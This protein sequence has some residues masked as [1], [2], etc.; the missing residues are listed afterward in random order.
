LIGTTNSSTLLAN[1]T[2]KLVE[3]VKPDTLYIQAT[4]NWWKIAKDLDVN[5]FIC[6]LIPNLNFLRLLTIY[7]RQLNIFQT[8]QEDSYQK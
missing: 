1:R 5:I 6:R 4:S 8:T 7:Q 2:K 3:D